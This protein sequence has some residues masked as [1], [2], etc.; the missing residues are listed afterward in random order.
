MIPCGQSVDALRRRAA[1]ADLAFQLSGHECSDGNVVG[2]LGLVLCEGFWSNVPD[3]VGSF[4]TCRHL[5][6]RGSNVIPQTAVMD[7]GTRIRC[8]RKDRT[9]GASAGIGGSELE[10]VGDAVRAIGV[11]ARGA[12]FNFR[13]SWG[14]IVDFEA[15]AFAF[16]L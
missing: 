6:R 9:F 14:R 15:F 7:F 4:A 8:E 10:I 13:D 2:R 1:R 11:H 16:G 3:R 12:G 5:E